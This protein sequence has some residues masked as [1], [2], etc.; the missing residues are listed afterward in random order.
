VNTTPSAP[1]HPFEFTG[2]GGEYFRIWI[3]NLALTLL[4]FGIYSAWAKVRRLQYFHRNTSLLGASFDYHA[5][6]IAILKGRLIAVGLLL[7]YQAAASLSPVLGALVFVVLVSALPWLLQRSLCFKLANSSYRG[8]RFRF[9]GSM[10]DAYRAFLLWPALGYVTLGALFPMAHQRIKAYQH[11]N[12]FYANARFGFDADV[13]SFYGV[14]LRLLG[15][16]LAPLMMFALV[17]G[18]LDIAAAVGDADGD[19]GETMRTIVKLVLALVAFYL[20]VF[21]LVA[22]W[23]LARMQNLVWNHTALGPHAF[24][25]EARARDM[26]VIYLTNFIAIV[27]TLGL[28]KPFA[29]VR[30]ARYRLTRMAV[31]TQ[32]N[33]DDLFAQDARAVNAMGQETA[34]VFDVDISF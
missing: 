4:T 16:V 17:A 29:D 20:L 15:L 22:P 23:F 26:L 19:P 32:G 3:V 27:A 30:V 2:K 14:Y 5:S 12:S 25:S 34:D 9:A 24:R 8:L 1:R 6:P 21:L 10:A 28:F 31:H 33:L 7:A 13:K 11:A 18:V